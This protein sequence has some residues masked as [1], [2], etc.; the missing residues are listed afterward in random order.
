MEYERA[1]EKTPCPCPPHVPL[2]GI[3][4]PFP[5]LFPNRKAK[6]N[7]RYAT[8]LIAR[9]SAVPLR[10]RLRR[11]EQRSAFLHSRRCQAAMCDTRVTR[12]RFWAIPTACVRERATHELSG[13]RAPGN[14]RGCSRR[15]LLHASRKLWLSGEL[16]PTFPVTGD[17]WLKLTDSFFS[18]FGAGACL[19]YDNNDVIGCV[20]LPI[21]H[22]AD[23]CSFSSCR[24]QRGRVNQ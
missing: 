14:R 1:G 23:W 24:S 10:V 2:R 7:M 5:R 17:E 13:P 11:G 20:T 6:R 19:T 18:P 4:Q 22:G 12:M 3:H 21:E 15:A 9:H 16:Q 8:P